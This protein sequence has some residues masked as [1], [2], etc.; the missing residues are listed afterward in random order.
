ML[1]KEILFK[2]IGGVKSRLDG[3]RDE[4]QHTSLHPRPLGNCPSLRHVHLNSRHRKDGPDGV[5][6]VKARLSGKSRPSNAE[7]R[8]GHD[9]Y[10]LDISIKDQLRNPGQYDRLIR[11]KSLSLDWLSSQNPITVVGNHSPGILGCYWKLHFTPA[12]AH[13]PTLNDSTSRTLHHNH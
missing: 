2:T 5:Q 6:N 1:P 13:L 10:P 7:S 11:L 8:T 9:T 4:Q 3:R 12:P